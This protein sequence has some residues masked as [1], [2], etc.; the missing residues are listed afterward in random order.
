MTTETLRAGVGLR[1]DRGPVLIAIMLSTSLIALD[2]TILATAVPSVVQELGG[3]SQFPWLFSVYLLAQAVTVPIYGKLADIYGRKPL[4]LAGVG[5]FVA[6]SLLCGIAWNLPVLIAFRAVQGLG[7]GAVQPIGI[8]II[9]DL[10]TVTERAR[11]QG[12]LA[13]VWA[14]SSVVGPALGGV[15]SEY[16]SWR[17]IFFVNLPLGAL[18]AWLLLRGF[19]ERAARSRPAIDYAGAATLAGGLSLLI[20]ALLEG[21]VAWPWRSPI[22]LGVIAGGLLLMGVF[23]LVERRAA[24]P[25]LPGWLFTRHVL[26]A[27]NLVAFF[28]G[29]VVFGLTSYIPAYVQG[30]LGSSALVA[31]FAL[32]AL[33]LGWP[34]AASLSGPFYL[35]AGFK[36][37]AAT[38]AVLVLAGAGL[39]TLFGRVTPVLAVAGV[40]FL[41]GAGLGLVNSPVLISIQSAVGWEQRGVATGTNLFGRSLGSA[42]GVAIFGA[43]ANGSLDGRPESDRAALLAASHLVFAA[44]AVAAVLMALAV[45]GMPR[46]AAEPA[47][48]PGP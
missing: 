32:G 44:T 26:V 47:A 9:G 37:T 43:I 24:A 13:S 1:S 40:C 42:V 19:T 25:I 11:V 38:G 15:F 4:I 27:G 20:L 48:P 36:A 12:Y 28:L 31:G 45:I 6:G 33:S 34:L 5:M 23:V 30:V 21:G 46:R 39:S 35:R 14:V 16:L 10:Y 41:V 17:W 2:A 3:F 8:T 7:A 18:A 29:A 22:S